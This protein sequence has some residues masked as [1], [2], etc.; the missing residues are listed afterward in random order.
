MVKIKMG[1]SSFTLV[2]ILI[3]VVV[4]TA[5]VTFALAGYSKAVDNING[6]KCQNN[7]LILHTAT[8]LYA[9]DHDDA[10]PASLSS[11]WPAYKDRA[12][13]KLKLDLE[14]KGWTAN[15]YADE[16]SRY[17]A[18]NIDVVTCPSDPTPPSKGGTSYAI[19]TSAAPG[20]IFIGDCDVDIDNL[21]EQTLK[22]R[23]RKGLI[24]KDT[25]YAITADGILEQVTTGGQATS[26]NPP[27]SG[28]TPGLGEEGEAGLTGE[29]TV[30]HLKKF[31]RNK[32]RWHRAGINLGK[33][34]ESIQDK[35]GSFISEEDKEALKNMIEAAKNAVAQAAEDKTK[36][37]SAKSTKKAAEDALEALKEKL[38]AKK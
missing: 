30:I 18:S 16:F 4:L 14:K 9:Q 5:L 28:E 7:L 22:Y 26:I 36:A 29:A 10:L 20:E 11:V 27:P 33:K 6:L 8:E 2:E 35:Y 25:A 21:S 19:N 3:V 15:A 37:E 24:A 12:L 17:Y 32:A 13:A 34:W 1:T 31:H 38:K 23:H